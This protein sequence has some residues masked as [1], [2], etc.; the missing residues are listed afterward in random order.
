MTTAQIKAMK[1]M[2]TAEGYQQTHGVMSDDESANG[3][4]FCRRDSEGRCE[5]ARIYKGVVE[6]FP[7]TDAS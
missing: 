6:R 2:L 3:L 4:W 7:A 5:T 1:T